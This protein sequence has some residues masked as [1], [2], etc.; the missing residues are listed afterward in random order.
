MPAPVPGYL[1]QWNAVPFSSGAGR[2]ERGNIAE[3]TF[4]NKQPEI[5]RAGVE[6]YVLR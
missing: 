4:T 3:E 5:Y 2:R 1:G 6:K